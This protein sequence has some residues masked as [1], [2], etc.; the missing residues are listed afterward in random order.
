MRWSP[1]SGHYARPGFS[2]SYY[3]GNGIRVGSG[4]FFG[5]IDWRQRHVNVINYNSFYYRNVN[6]CPNLGHR[7]LHD[8][9]HR[10]GAPYRSPALHEHFN[11]VPSNTD[12]RGEFRGRYPFAPNNGAYFPR[13][14]RGA[15]G[16]RG[17][18]GDRGD[19][20]GDPRPG[21]QG[22]NAFVPQ[23][24]NAARRPATLPG[25]V[26]NAPSN[27]GS[28]QTSTWRSITASTR[29]RGSWRRGAQ[30]GHIRAG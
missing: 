8:P 23:A 26:P 20:R 11:R 17:D 22:T 30:R 3:W 12:A 7:W 13:D 24:D 19:R 4:F 29:R 9:D 18:R 15:Q 28:N 2:R 21:Q 14:D 16:G 6:R 1:W 5:G 27:R 10:H 25:P